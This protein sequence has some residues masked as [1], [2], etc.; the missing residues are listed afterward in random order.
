M[1]HRPLLP[2]LIQIAENQFTNRPTAFTRKR[3]MGTVHTRRHLPARNPQPSS[4]SLFVPTM[5]LL[6]VQWR[7]SRFSALCTDRS[8][9]VCALAKAASADYV[10]GRNPIHE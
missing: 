10:A 3:N 7:D 2:G 6:L 4:C 5:T 1:R 9:R 8:V